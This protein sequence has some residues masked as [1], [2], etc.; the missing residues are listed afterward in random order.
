LPL[1]EIAVT[2]VVVVGLQ[3]LWAGL[4]IT[5]SVDYLVAHAVGAALVLLLVLLQCV[6]AIVLWRPG[7]G[8]RWPMLFS[9]VE[10]V[11]V[12]TQMALGGAR[13]LA[14]H[15]VLGMALFGV[16]L[17]FACWACSARASRRRGHEVIR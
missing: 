8:S 4:F 12:F 3:P 10:V 2:T 11:L 13:A 9:A 6:A 17:L 14:G 1:R 16:T 5:G 15:F 7:H